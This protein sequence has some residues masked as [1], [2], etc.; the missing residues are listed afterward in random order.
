M[1]D[2][3]RLAPVHGSRCRSLLISYLLWLDSS[4]G[5]DVPKNAYP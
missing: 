3:L 5:T 2:D 4:I 1:F